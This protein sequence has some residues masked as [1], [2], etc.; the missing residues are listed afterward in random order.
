[1]CGSIF[2][3]S[4]IALILPIKKKFWPFVYAKYIRVEDKT[5]SQSLSVI[6]GTR[7]N[8][9]DDVTR[10]LCLTGGETLYRLLAQLERHL[11]EYRRHNILLYKCPRWTRP[12]ICSILEQ[13]SPSRGAFLLLSVT[14]MLRPLDPRAG[15][16]GGGQPGG[17][18]SYL[19]PSLQPLSSLVKWVTNKML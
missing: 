1:M 3:L 15:T 9:R 11:F 17:S 5:T 6:E 18:G 7:R 10:P 16:T 19:G 8:T 13:W 12:M 4:S 2:E 14:W